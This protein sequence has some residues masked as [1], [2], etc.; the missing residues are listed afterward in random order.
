MI[1]IINEQAQILEDISTKIHLALLS[2]TA[3]YTAENYSI[4]QK[5][6][7]QNL[8]MIRI[9]EKEE[10]YSLIIGALTKQERAQI[11]EIPPDWF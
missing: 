10:Y 5:H 4:P 6:H 2:S 1:G 3:N 7:E 8:F 9:L 11:V